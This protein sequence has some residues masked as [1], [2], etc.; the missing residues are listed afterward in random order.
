MSEPIEEIASSRYAARLLAA[1]P[2]LSAE[3]AD[4]AAFSRD[5]MAHALAGAQHDDEASLKRRFRQLRQRVLLRVMARDLAG[6]AD[7]AEVCGTMSDLAELAL[8]VALEHANAALRAEFGT[9]RSPAGDVQQLVIV[10]MGKLGGRELNVSS[11]VDLVLVYPEDGET[12]GRRKLS[13]HEYFERLGRRLIA[14]LAENT[15]DGFVFRVDMRLRPYGD[16]GA[17]VTSFDALEAYLVAHGREWER[18]AWIKARALS[19]DRHDELDAIVRPFVFRKYLDFATLAAMRRLHAE[20]RREVAR[21]ELAEHVKLGPGGIREIE[22]VV[23]AL[24]LIRGGREPELTVRPTLDAL[25]ELSRKRLLPELAAQEL[26]DA[27]VFLRRVEHRLQYLDDQQTHMLP[28]DAENRARIAAMAGFAD[29]QPFY[30]RLGDTRAVVTRHFQDV[31]AESEAGLALPQDDREATARELEALGFRDPPG[32]PARWA[33]ELVTRHPVL[34]DELLDDRLLEALPDWPGFEGAL[35]SAL[36]AAAGDTER[37]MNVLREEHRAQVFRLL[38]QDL[39]GL[40][41]VERLAD[42]LSEL[43]DRVLG[44]TLEL[45]WSQLPA[46]HRSQPRFAIIGYGK[47][48][49][50]ELGYASDLDLIFLYDDADERAA[51][52]Y[53]RL[54][55][56]LYS[57]LTSHTSSGV[58]FETDLR[59][60][61]SGASGMLVSSIAA[62]DEY[63]KNMAWVWEH[64]ALTRARYCAGDKAVGDAFEAIRETILKRERDVSILAREILSMREKMHAAHPN[65]SGLFDVK[66]DQG[67][68]IDIE[69]IVQFLVLAH[70]HRFPDL[71]GN[72]G[73]IALLKIDRKSVV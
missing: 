21:R 70:A 57:W 23:Q 45:V 39:A 58:L 4:P 46:R 51:E 47:L 56:R 68:M 30:E 9:P 52:N 1:R 59:L 73:N 3:L 22:F 40:L 2:E 36:A 53:A 37:L 10:G 31:L 69:F 60:R 28:E 43:A 6:R 32:G 12:D 17:L 50:K 33:A 44:V 16:S 38:A 65:R 72:L 5:E 26:A 62:F 54:A 20:V 14:A 66:H 24:Q 15:E 8:Q 48:G 18:Y 63:Q 19:G 71:T 55:Q 61:P 42:H 29:W 11:D 35:R 25:A 13:N 67:G 34:F 27:Y 64:Q 49:G 7:L 41:T